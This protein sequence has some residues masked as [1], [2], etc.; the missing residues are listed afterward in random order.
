[1][2]VEKVPTA[3]SLQVLSILVPFADTLPLQS[4]LDPRSVMKVLT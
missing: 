4:P 2:V 3:V 1:M